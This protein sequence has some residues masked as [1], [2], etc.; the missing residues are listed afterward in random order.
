M[1]QVIHLGLRV[2]GHFGDENLKEGID[3]VEIGWEAVI[4]LSP[5]GV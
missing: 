1:I 4:E 5:S 3:D 2:L